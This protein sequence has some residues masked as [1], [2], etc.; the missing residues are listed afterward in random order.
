MGRP[1]TRTKGKSYIET[2]RF[3]SKAGL[4][5]TKSTDS[6]VTDLDK[7]ENLND[8][9]EKVVGV[10][11]HFENKQGRMIYFIMYD[12]ENNKIRNHIAKYLLRKG[13]I[14][15]QK[16]VFLA[17]SE[18]QKYDE[19][20][21]T[22]KEVQEMYD[23]NDSIFFIPVSVDEIRA[24]KIIGRNVDFSMVIDTPNTLFY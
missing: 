11:R 14:R 9:I 23:N 22:L 7:I 18:R 1:K 17:E 20:N 15:V 12:I 4:K 3:L 19:L 13:C 8:R 10:Y 6:K 24:M 5:G 21:S 16:S 2:L